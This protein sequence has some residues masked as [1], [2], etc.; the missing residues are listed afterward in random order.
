MWSRFANLEDEEVTFAEDA[1]VVDL[2]L[3]VPLGVG[4]ESDGRVRG[5]DLV[6]RT[7]ASFLTAGQE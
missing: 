4:R 7:M 6:A 3:V 5:E 2:K 1:Q